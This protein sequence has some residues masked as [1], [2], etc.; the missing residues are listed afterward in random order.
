MS[1]QER[2][3]CPTCRSG[4]NSAPGVACN[5]CESTG[6]VTVTVV[7]SGEGIID[8]DDMESLRRVFRYAI[9]AYQLALADVT[10]DLPDDEFQEAADEHTDALDEV[11]DEDFDRIAALLEGKAI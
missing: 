10:P 5:D 9:A 3:R 1:R 8:D 7:E 2:F 6:F 11:T 4:G